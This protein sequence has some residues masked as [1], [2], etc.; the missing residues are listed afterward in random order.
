MISISTAGPTKGDGNL[1]WRSPV[2]VI[3]VG[4]LDALEPGRAIPVRLDE[5][6]REALVVR[7]G[8]TS[9]VAFDRRCP[10]R[11]CAVVWSVA[12]WRFEC[13]CHRASFDARSG[14]VLEGPPGAGLEPLHLQRRHDGI[15]LIRADDRAAP[16]PVTQDLTGC[17]NDGSP[18]R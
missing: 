15:W 18:L 2:E 14:A 5:A 6:G 17:D 7:N 16:R 4:H 10:H 9:V 13:P 3:E 1:E 12:L 11:G 8:A